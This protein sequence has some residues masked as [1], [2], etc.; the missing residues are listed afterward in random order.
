MGTR[1]R[2]SGSTTKTTAAASR[3]LAS[4]RRH[5]VGLMLEHLEGRA[6]NGVVGV[7][8]EAERNRAAQVRGERI[9]ELSFLVSERTLALAAADVEPRLKA[10]VCREGHHTVVRDI[11]RLQHL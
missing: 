9:E 4:Y 8:P 7:D 1:R 3:R 6:V 11:L 10:V 2:L 5:A